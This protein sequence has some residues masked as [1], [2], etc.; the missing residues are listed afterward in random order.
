[1]ERLK[2]L[3]MYSRAHYFC[4]PPAIVIAVFTCP[5][6]IVSRT[7]PARNQFFP[8]SEFIALIICTEVFNV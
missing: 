8:I 7:F 5:R 1:M 2:I 4:F 3:M 6:N